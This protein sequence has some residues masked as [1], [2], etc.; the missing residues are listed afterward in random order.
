MASAFQKAH[1]QRRAFN[2]MRSMLASREPEALA[3]TGVLCRWVGLQLARVR[4]SVWRSPSEGGSGG[5]R[6]GKSASQGSKGGTLDVG[7][8]SWYL[9]RAE[10]SRLRRR[11]PPFPARFATA[12]LE[13]A[14]VDHAGHGRRAAVTAHPGK[15]AGGEPGSLVPHPRLEPGVEGGELPFEASLAIVGHPGCADRDTIKNRARL[16]GHNST[17]VPCIAYTWR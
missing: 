7:G 17:A 15:L 14:L 4:R 3:Q 10:L 2:L 6:T 13:V 16:P 11:R 9:V 1:L 12:E 8:A 5:Q